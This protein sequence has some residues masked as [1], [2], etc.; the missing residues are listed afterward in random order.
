M[1]A[2]GKRPWLDVNDCRLR[3]LLI[4]IWFPQREVHPQSSE[5]AC[6]HLGHLGVALLHGQ[7]QGHQ[8]ADQ[9]LLQGRGAR[10]PQLLDHLAV[11]ADAGG[12]HLLS[13][14]GQNP[15]AQVCSLLQ[16]VPGP[17]CPTWKHHSL[18]STHSEE[19]SRHKRHPVKLLW[20]QCPPHWNLDPSSAHSSQPGP[21][22]TYH[23][24]EKCPLCW[25]QSKNCAPS[26]W[27]NGK[28]VTFPGSLDYR[29]RAP[30]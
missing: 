24:V 11:Q 3:M 10:R 25:D 26:R 28:E 13:R 20:G 5:P 19:P 14:L 17:L 9:L 16:E 6:T 1:G 30:L 22:L 23:Q 7:Q 27:T 8:G 18:P 4:L 15:E 29:R 2:L 21:P 12:A